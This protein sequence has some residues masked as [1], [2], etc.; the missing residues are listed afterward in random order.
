MKETGTLNLNDQLMSSSYEWLIMK[1]EREKK[2]NS[3]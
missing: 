1:K 3:L 2:I